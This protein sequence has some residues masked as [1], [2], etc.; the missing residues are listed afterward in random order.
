[1]RGSISKRG[2]M[3]RVIFDV[4]TK[5]KRVQK[6]K[7]GFKTIKEAQKFLNKV[8]SEI[9]E[10]TYKE[11][12]KELFSSFINEWFEKSYKRSVEETT[13]ETRWDSLKN[14][15]IPYFQKTPLNQITTRMLD[16]FYNDK[17]DEGLAPKTVREF[18]NL[19]RK[20]FSQAVKWSLL[21]HNPAIDATPPHVPNRKFELWTKDETKSFINVAGENKSE[22]VF[23]TFIFT[24]GRRGE[25]LG[26]KWSDIDFE[27]GKIRIVRSL[28][29]TQKRGLF[30]KMLRHPV[31]EG[32]FQFLLIWW[33]N[34]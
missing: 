34:C 31:Q 27:T 33:K 2:K 6:S 8:L 9:N 1:M 12:S 25:I 26:L 13:A 11:S 3:Y 22:T 23:E 5:H 32:K 15:I 17:L 4:G 29:K 28:A 20:A 14:H 19:L 30:L 21:K 7:G 10:G 18:H 24:G 16:D